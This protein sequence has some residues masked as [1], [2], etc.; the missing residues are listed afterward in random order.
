MNVIIL[1]ETKQDVSDMKIRN[2]SELWHCS[3]YYEAQKWVKSE[4]R[5]REDL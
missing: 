3:G 2:G 5:S 1:S 4:T